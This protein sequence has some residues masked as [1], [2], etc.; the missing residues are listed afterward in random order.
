MIIE[1]QAKELADGTV[2]EVAHKIEILC[3]SCG[4]D[5]DS[6]ELEAEKCG[7]CGADLS[8]PQQNVELHA[9]SIPLFAITF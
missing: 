5:V 2:V 7:D 1:N 6:A 4:K 3:P 9:T 8:S